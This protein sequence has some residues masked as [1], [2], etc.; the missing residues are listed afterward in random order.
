MERIALEPVDGVD[1]TPPPACPITFIP[2]A[3]GSRLES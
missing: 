2:N 1:V 3:V